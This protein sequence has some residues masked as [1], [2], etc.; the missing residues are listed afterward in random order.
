MQ[1]NKLVQIVAFSIALDIW[2][3]EAKHTSGVLGGGEWETIWL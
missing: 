2:W 1:K 3:A